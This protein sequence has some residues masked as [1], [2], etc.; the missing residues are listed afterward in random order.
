M[1]PASQISSVTPRSAVTGTPRA[2]HGEHEFRRVRDGVCAVT[3]LT[4]AER[5]SGRPAGRPAAGAADR[6][7]AR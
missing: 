3:G 1:R 6:A 5:A 2:A 7:A 4:A